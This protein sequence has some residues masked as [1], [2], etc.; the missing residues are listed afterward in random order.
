MRARQSLSGAAVGT[1]STARTPAARRDARVTVRA[2]AAPMSPNGPFL[3]TAT[4]GDR[5]VGQ[6]QVDLSGR[7]EIAIH[8]L[9]V[10]PAFRGAGLG[11]ALVAAALRFGA[12]AGRSRARLEADDDG[13][14]RLIRWYRGLGFTPI[15]TSPRGL[16]TMQADLRRPLSAGRRSELRARP[17]R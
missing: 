8:D 5:N 2:G 11:T 13:S 4:V 17:T 12:R 14:G 16:P 9:A 1:R 3:F 15:G 10:A 7:S 6:V